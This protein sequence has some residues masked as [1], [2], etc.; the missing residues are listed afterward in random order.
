[1]CRNEQAEGS[2][3]LVAAEFV[4]RICLQRGGVRIGGDTRTAGGRVAEEGSTGVR[5]AANR[6][7]TGIEWTTRVTL[8][9]RH[10]DTEMKIEAKPHHQNG[11]ETRTRCEGNACNAQSIERNAAYWLSKNELL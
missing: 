10:A 6:P 8:C 3:P 9:L 4:A 1:M 11:P 7:G 2:A 5:R